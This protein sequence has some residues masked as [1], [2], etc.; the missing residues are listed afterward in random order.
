MHKVEADGNENIV[1]FLKHISKG[2]TTATVR[3]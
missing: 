2:N 3:E 1:S